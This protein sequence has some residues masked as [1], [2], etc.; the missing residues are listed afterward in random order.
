MLNVATLSGL[1]CVYV[2]QKLSTAML[3]LDRSAVGAKVEPSAR[4]TSL[5]P[6]RYWVALGLW[7]VLLEATLFWADPNF[8]ASHL[9]I[10]ARDSDSK[11]DAH[12]PPNSLSAPTAGAGW[13]VGIPSWAPQPW[14]KDEPTVKV[15]D[16]GVAKLTLGRVQ[17]VARGLLGT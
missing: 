4:S 10:E 11:W 14:S 5:W 12:G 9:F 8:Q 16:F 13:Q 17:G 6:N 15:C 3:D 2:L 1:G 7:P